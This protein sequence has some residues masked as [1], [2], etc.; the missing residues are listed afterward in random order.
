[1]CLA[2][3]SFS[4]GSCII[5]MANILFGLPEAPEYIKELGIPEGYAPQLTM[6]L[7]YRDGE[8]AQV[9]H[10]DPKINFID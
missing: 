5:G 6:I 2:A 7:G 10:L 3:E 8:P 9:E 1:M 4:I